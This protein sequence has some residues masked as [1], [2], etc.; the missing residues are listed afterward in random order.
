MIFRV[1]T[2]FLIGMN[3]TLFCPIIYECIIFAV[4]NLHYFNFLHCF[5]SGGYGGGGGGYDDRGGYGGGGGGGYD[6]RY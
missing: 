6:N 5:F 3:I 4:L 2:V 1:L